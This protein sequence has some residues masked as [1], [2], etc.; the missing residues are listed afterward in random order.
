MPHLF[1]DYKNQIKGG[2]LR[3]EAQTRWGKET[4]YFPDE[5][6]KSGKA[7]YGEAKGKEKLLNFSR[8]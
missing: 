6:E 8:I 3:R 5:N 1:P 2:N 4:Q 7:G